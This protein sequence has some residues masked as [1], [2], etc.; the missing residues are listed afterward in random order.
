MAEMI[1][2]TL[3]KRTRGTFHMSGATRLSRYEFSKNLAEA[4]GLDPKYLIPVQ[5]EQ[6]NW[7]ARRPKDSSLSVNKAEQTLKNKPLSIREALEKM[8][9][10]LT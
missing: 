2:E 7:I 10:E 8:K 4:F 1:T 9:R 5:A 3:E 6:M